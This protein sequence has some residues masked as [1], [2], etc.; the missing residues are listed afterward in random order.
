MRF[1]L[2]NRYILGLVMVLALL[3]GCQLS[4]VTV[5]DTLDAP[6]VAPDSRVQPVL[7]W[8]LESESGLVASV[9]AE[10]N[11]GLTN[12][13][14]Q[15]PSWKAGAANPNPVNY[16]ALS[17]FVRAVERADSDPGRDWIRRHVRDSVA[18]F[19]ATMEYDGNPPGEGMRIVDG[20]V[21]NWDSD[22]RRH[23]NVAGFVDA[24]LTYPDL[25]PFVRPM[26]VKWGE[27]ILDYNIQKHNREYHRFGFQL[28]SLVAIYQITGDNVWL[29]RAK[30]FFWW[31]WGE[32]NQ[33]V[34]LDA[35]GNEWHAWDT[36]IPG[37]DRGSWMAHMSVYAYQVGPI[38]ASWLR[39]YP[40]A[41]NAIRAR[42]IY[43]IRL[44]SDW[45]LG[46]PPAIISPAAWKGKPNTP[47]QGV[48][49]T[50]EAWLALSDDTPYGRMLTLEV[51]ETDGRYGDLHFLDDAG[52]AVKRD[53][54]QD[55]LAPVLRAGGSGFGIP[56]LLWARYL[57]EP[58][59][60]NRLWALWALHDYRG[61]CNRM[62]ASW[63]ATKAARMG[64]PW[65][66]AQ[67]RSRGLAWWLL[68]GQYSVEGFLR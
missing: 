5:P 53:H 64:D 65:S 30:A 58:T 2:K 43:L 55:K 25:E 15:W 46:T 20:V 57:I 59:Q 49:I 48:S 52:N 12:T 32:Q 26:A 28:D 3:V 14:C 39:L 41:D 6:S 61:H 68:A 54:H 66:G 34:V 27:W 40:H 67:G 60:T 18:T 37:E 23:V 42:I 47:L 10:S 8:L 1:V 9:V 11:D 13:K 33:R 63:T 51:H 4:P 21:I 16:G 38:V 35:A 7:D 50:P 24:A 19:W 62:S 31:A 29:D 45:Y 17:P 44:W 22:Y 36:G 56:V